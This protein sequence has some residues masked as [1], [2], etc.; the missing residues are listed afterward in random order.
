MSSV[1]AIAVGLTFGFG[2]AFALAC[3]AAGV[4]WALGITRPPDEDYH[5]MTWLVGFLVWGGAAMSGWFIAARDATRPLWSA[6]IAG[7]VIF[8]VQAA[9]TPYAAASWTITLRWLAIYGII[10]VAC[11][12]AGALANLALS[13][14]R[15]MENA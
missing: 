7:G 9:F 2:L 5:A 1:R 15:E 13:R 8:L 11:A 4:W 14:R 3:I 10:P 12:H 6:A